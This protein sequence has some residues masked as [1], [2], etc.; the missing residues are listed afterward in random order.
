MNKVDGI[1]MGGIVFVNNVEFADRTMRIFVDFKKPL[2]EKSESVSL[3]RDGS[4]M[5]EYFNTRVD[6]SKDFEGCITVNYGSELFDKLLKSM[7]ENPYK[8]KRGFPMAGWKF[9]NETDTFKKY[10]YKSRSNYMKE[11]FRV[12]PS[13]HSSEEQGK[14]LQSFCKK[15][16]EYMSEFWESFDKAIEEGNFTPIE[17]KYKRFV[18]R[19]ENPRGKKSSSSVPDFNPSMD[20][21]SNLGTPAVLSKTEIQNATLNKL[22]SYCDERGI[23][24]KSSDTR[25]SLR[26]ALRKH[27]N[28]A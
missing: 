9:I 13:G 22:R 19:M 3:N 5:V 27:Y 18:E 6:N 25:T 2:Y 17:E 20:L 14:I 24:H 7:Q 26:K 10:N 11:Y 21:G 15:F 1:F 8:S 12:K 16:P 23:S 4:T 28:Y